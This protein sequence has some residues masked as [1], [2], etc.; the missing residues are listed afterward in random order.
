MVVAMLA[1]GA[2][3]AGVANGGIGGTKAPL[4][5]TPFITGAHVLDGSLTGADI[6]QATLTGVANAAHANAADSATN[7]GH[8]TTADSASSATN[9]TNAGNA[10]ALGGDAAGSYLERTLK[11][12]ETETGVF[13]GSSAGSTNGSNFIQAE[14][15]FQP[16]L[17]AD[18][19]VTSCPQ[20][21]RLAVGAPP[22][23]NCPG[24]GRAA[25]GHL[26]LYEG[27]NDN[28]TFC[29][30][31][32][33]PQTGGTAIRTYGTLVYWSI[34]GDTSGFVRGNWA[35]TAP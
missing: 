12:G 4:A 34:A 35:L 23:A 32:A 1:L 20:V 30:A 16:K 17:A 10:A 27:R 22:T 28:G 31:A 24:I 29:C 13:G 15:T 11:P 14:I 3:L 33:D 25:R 6:N 19:C 18:L 9:A 5:A 2:A 21:E 8:A 26:C 7:A